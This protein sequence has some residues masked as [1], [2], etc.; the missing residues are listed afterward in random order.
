MSPQ[1][2]EQKQ[3]IETFQLD[4][5]TPVEIMPPPILIIPE[6]LKYLLSAAAGCIVADYVGRAA[7]DLI[8]SFLP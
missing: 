5:N 1:T 8:I 2:L 4:P 3:T 7:G 6:N